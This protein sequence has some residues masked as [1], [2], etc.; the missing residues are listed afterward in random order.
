MLGQESWSCCWPPSV[1][2]GRMSSLIQHNDHKLRP[3]KEVALNYKIGSLKSVADLR[4]HE[5]QFMALLQA[6]KQTFWQII[7]RL[8]KESVNLIT[9]WRDQPTR[10]GWMIWWS[11]IS[12]EP[13]RTTTTWSWGRSPPR[14]T[15]IARNR[16]TLPRLNSKQTGLLTENLL[17]RYFSVIM[18][19]MV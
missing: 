15:N 4:L 7:L 11:C 6:I 3:W 17:K 16:A 19:I 9:R 8:T 12:A 1:E 14:S 18:V 5:W 10:I 2:S 13:G